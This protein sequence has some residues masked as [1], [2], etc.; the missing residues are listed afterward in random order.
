MTSNRLHIILT[1]LSVFGLVF[2]ACGQSLNNYIQMAQSHNP[3]IKAF[4]KQHN[5]IT[6]KINEVNVYPNT[7]FSAGFFTSEPKT[8]NGAQHFKIS[9]SQMLPQFG[10]ISAKENYVKALTIEKEQ[11]I[12]ITKRKIATAVTRLY[13]NLYALKAKQIVLEENVILLNT[14][15]TLILS[16][17]QSGK[18][19]AVTVFRLQMQRNEIKA[20][21]E[22]LEHQFTGKQAEMN[23]LLNREPNKK[24]TILNT[25]DIPIGQEKVNKDSL[26]VHPELIKYDKLY[27]SVAKSELVNQKEDNVKLGFGL[28]YVSI[29]KRPNM[30]FNHNG[31]DVFMP[32][33]SLSVPLFNSKHKSVTLQNKLQQDV[34]KAQREERLNN[35]QTVLNTAIA[36]RNVAL[37]SNKTQIKNI[38]QAKDAEQL[39][40][41]YYQTGITNFNDVLEIQELQLKFQINRIES[42]KAYYVQSAIINYL[43]Q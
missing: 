13:Y 38:K 32:M 4:E 12:I 17:I 1:A 21:K 34:I 20:Q 9:A 6:E 8:R 28:D 36:N 16:S 27:E 29:R 26:R 14:Y 7:Q 5:L 40:L 41:N 2:T 25:L 37:V 3:K 43:T 23:E 22:I 42:I 11:D 39:L 31:K 15:E 30:E 18:S 24:V 19:S 35:L 10:L 33:V